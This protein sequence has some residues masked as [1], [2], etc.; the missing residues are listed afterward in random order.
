ME[1]NRQVIKIGN[2]F[3][4]GAEQ[5]L[6][7]I[8][9]PCQIESLEHCLMIAEYVQSICRDLKIN[10]IFKAS[11]DK[12][13]RTSLNSQRGPGLEA[14]L[15]ILGTVKEKLGVPVLTDIHESYQAE[16]A[17]EVADVLQIPAFLCRQ[18][19]ILIAAGKTQR[20]INIKK[21]QF[22]AAADLKYSAEKVAAQGNPNIMLCERGNTFGYRELVVDFRNL[23]IMRAI[24]YPVVFDATHSV[25]IMG[26]NSGSSGGNRQ[27]ISSLTRAAAAVGIDALFLEC[28]DRPD[29]APSDGPNMLPLEQVRPLLEAVLQIRAIP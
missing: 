16:I 29:Q 1:S 8:A 4:I 18:S 2:N 6:A 15:K 11:F 3:K 7:L 19:D 20:A 22:L 21:G 9:G 13:N 23:E 24:G 17:A 12:A 28:H 5:P 10:F 26:G 14:G 25:Q 27:F